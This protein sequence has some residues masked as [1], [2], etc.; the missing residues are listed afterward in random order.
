VALRSVSERGRVPGPVSPAAPKPPR[1][2]RRRVE[3]RDP[4]VREGL[5]LLRAAPVRRVRHYVAQVKHEDKIN[6][7]PKVDGLLSQVRQ[8]FSVPFTLPDSPRERYVSAAYVFNSGAIT[9]NAQ[10]YMMNELRKE[11]YGTTRTSSMGTGSTPLTAGR[12]TRR[13][14]RSANASSD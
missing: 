12:P 14:A 7:G 11:R 9:D 10:T 2:L 4:R 13:T 6:Q 1:L 5:R 3:A 8:A